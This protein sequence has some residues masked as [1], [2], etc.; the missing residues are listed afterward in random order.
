MSGSGG[1]SWSRRGLQPSGHPSGGGSG[2]RQDAASTDPCD[3][4]EVT[5]LNSPNRSVLSTLQVGESLNIEF[6]QG[7]PRQLLAKRGDLVAG[8]ITSPSSMRIIQC[9]QGDNREY[10]AVVRS[11]LGGRCEVEIQLI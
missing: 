2:G 1:G 5:T 4:T 9:I 7:P 10:V 6:V 3:I 11:I 8:S